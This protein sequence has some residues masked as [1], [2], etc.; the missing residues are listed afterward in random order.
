MRFHPHHSVVT[1]LQA[2][3]DFASLYYS[4]VAGLDHINDF[5]CRK[6]VIT[7]QHLGF[8]SSVFHSI[9]VNI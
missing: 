2:L 8:S 9:I 4:K 1:G 5:M 3:H 7:K 6:T